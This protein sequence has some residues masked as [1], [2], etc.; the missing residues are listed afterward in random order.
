MQQL[1][2][3]KQGNSFSITLPQE[4]VEKLNVAEGDTLLIT[5]NT[6]KHSITL[7]K[8]DESWE[9]AMKI[10]RQGSDK[11]SHALKELAQ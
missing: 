4:L 3:N 10:Y 11:Y 2:I 8:Y 6:D 1:I 9:K 7:S 5:E